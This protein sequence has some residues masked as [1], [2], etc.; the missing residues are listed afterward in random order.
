MHR[1]T[2]Q[3]RNVKDHH[4][5]QAEQTQLAERDRPRQKE[6]HFDVEKDEQHG[7]Q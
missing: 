1:Q 5:D 7:D 4:L 3:D 2:N 6:H